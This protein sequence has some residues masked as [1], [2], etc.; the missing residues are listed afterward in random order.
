MGEIDVHLAATVIHQPGSRGYVV[1]PSLILK[2]NRDILLKLL[3]QVL[4]RM[5]SEFRRNPQNPVRLRR[6][7]LLNPIRNPIQPDPLKDF[8][9][10]PS[11][12]GQ[13]PEARTQG[14]Y[15]IQQRVDLN[16]SIIILCP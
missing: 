1:S 11:P 6:P 10:Q 13:P 3:F 9:E 8:P 16:H 12:V 5:L 2:K 14:I 15:P 4:R 7:P